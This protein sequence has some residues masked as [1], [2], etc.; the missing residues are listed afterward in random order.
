MTCSDCRKAA[1]CL[2]WHGY[3]ADCADCAIRA[4][5]QAPRE[6][7]ELRYDQITRSVGIEAAAEV[8][9]RVNEERARIEL[10]KGRHAGQHR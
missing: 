6:L 3:S 10:L 2:T 5:A 7:R 9:R 4:I 1:S 8:R